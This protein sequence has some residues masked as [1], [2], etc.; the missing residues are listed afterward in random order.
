ME[1]LP[2]SG[3]HSSSSTCCSRYCKCGLQG[4]GIHFRSSQI[5]SRSSRKKFDKM[6]F[7]ATKMH[8]CGDAFSIYAPRGIRRLPGAAFFHPR[9]Y[10][11]APR[12]CR[13]KT[14]GPPP[15]GPR[16][17]KLHFGAGGCSIWRRCR[18][19]V[20]QVCFFPGDLR[21]KTG[22]YALQRRRSSPKSLTCAKIM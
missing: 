9:R 7:G 20:A 8:R 13:G 6:S 21:R 19:M 16:P 1:K 3:G 17:L 22:S 12:G 5:F 18:G 10:A 14:P 15:I 2:A 11:A 4:S